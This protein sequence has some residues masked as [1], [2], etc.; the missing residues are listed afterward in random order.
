MTCSKAF[1][2]LFSL[3]YSL[4][5]RVLQ[6]KTCHDVCS[7]RYL[8]LQSY[9]AMWFIS[10]PVLLKKALP[11]SRQSSSQIFRWIYMRF[12]LC[13]SSLWSDDLKLCSLCVFHL[14]QLTQISKGTN[15]SYIYPPKRKLTAGGWRVDGK[16]VP[17]N[18][19]LHQSDQALICIPSSAAEEPWPPVHTEE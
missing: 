3:S 16:V 12:S 6:Q 11:R 13:L 14:Y 9:M 2:W 1:F 15:A 10:L 17:V 18:W 8:A 5:M 7:Q 19:G 4:C